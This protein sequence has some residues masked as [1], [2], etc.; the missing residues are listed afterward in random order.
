MKRYYKLDKNGK[1]LA[2]YARQQEGQELLHLE[3]PENSYHEW[4]GSE[5]IFNQDRYDT[6]TAIDDLSQSD[7]DMIRVI[8]DLIDVLIDKNVIVIDDLP[9]EAKDKINNRKSLRDKIK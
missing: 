3:E 7:N 8:E 4:N 5:W 1:I 6:E 2:S 9:V